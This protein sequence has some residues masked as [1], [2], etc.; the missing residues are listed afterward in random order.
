MGA[1][2]KALLKQKF[3]ETN[4]ADIGIQ[5]GIYIG[6]TPVDVRALEDNVI[7]FI[8]AQALLD[9]LAQTAGGIAI[10]DVLPDLDLRDQNNVAIVP[11]NWQQPVSGGF[12]GAQTGASATYV[13]QTN[14]DCDNTQKTICFMGVMCIN[15]GPDDASTAVNT[16]CVEWQRNGSK[17]IDEWHIQVVDQLPNRT[18]WAR[19]PVMFKKGDNARVNLIAKSTNLSGSFD[20]L[21][22]IGKVAEPLGKLING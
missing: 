21:I 6:L 5:G 15:G 16:C 1:Q 7:R 20:N 9:Q 2:A 11:R 13:Y 19:T 4:P 22:F 10:R 8:T 3:D 14:K 17:T 18:C 12:V